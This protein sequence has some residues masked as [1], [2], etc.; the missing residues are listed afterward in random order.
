MSSLRVGV[1]A[2]VFDPIHLGHSYFI[3]KTI[4]EKRLDKIYVLV[5]KRPR[6]KKCAASYEHRLKMT[7]IALKDIPEVE[8]YEGE[9]EYFPIT[10]DLP[11][12]KKANPEAK[13]H[14]LLGEDVAEHIGDWE[15]PNA[16]LEGVEL[17]I[18]KR[19]K[20]EPYAEASSLKIRKSLKNNGPVQLDPS[21]A[22]YIKKNRLY[23]GI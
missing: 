2:G 17:I 1:F 20:G 18:A 10:A 14:L 15:D 8:I 9:S 16:A 13:I 7:R 12:I 21:V 5:E 4:A 11:T 19:K 6:Y 23:T 3:K 22:D